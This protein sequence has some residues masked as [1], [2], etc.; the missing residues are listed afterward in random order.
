MILVLALFNGETKILT[1]NGQEMK[2]YN[3]DHS[4]YKTIQIPAQTGEFTVNVVSQHIFDSDDDLEFMVIDETDVENGILYNT[5]IYN[6]DGT[7]LLKADGLAPIWNSS[8]LS[9]FNF[10]DE[11][12]FSTFIKETSDGLKL[13]L[14]SAYYDYG[15]PMVTE[16]ILKVYSLPGS[17]P[18]ITS[19]DSP[20]S[21]PQN[22]LEAY[23]NPA[24]SVVQIGYELPEN[25]SQGV[26]KIYNEQG[27][28]VKS[29]TV[30]HTFD[31]L[32]LNVADFNAGVYTY[33]LET[34]NFASEAQKLVVMR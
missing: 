8:E 22:L 15:T 12:T 10:V 1:L 5:V 21:A 14:T 33:R 34:D 28:L 26:V 18:K 29:L 25:A 20:A 13:Y 19:V 32:L 23:P 30:D 3:E 24:S 2:I 27:I 31:H 7:V 11:S 6:E 9:S 16:Q 4:L 17:L